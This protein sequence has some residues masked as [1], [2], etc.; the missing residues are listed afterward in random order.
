MANLA[1]AQGVIGMAAFDRR[2]MPIMRLCKEKV[3]AAG[4]INQVVS[5]CY[6]QHDG[7]PYYGGAIDILSCD[8]VHAVDALRFMGGDVVDCV[9]S[10]R[11]LGKKFDTSFTAMVEFESGA[12]GVLLAN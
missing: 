8:A 5:T 3:Q 12:I 10:V 2:Y 7:G 1:E 4:P 9:S 6:K 11:S